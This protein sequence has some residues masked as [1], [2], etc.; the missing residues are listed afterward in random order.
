LNACSPSPCAQSVSFSFDWGYTET[1]GFFLGNVIPGSATG[2]TTGSLGTFGLTSPGFA[3]GF[4]GFF[5]SNPSLGTSFDTFVGNG[6]LESAP[7]SPTFFGAQMFGC[8]TPTCETDFSGLKFPTTG[9]VDIGILNYSV[10]EIPVPEPST[11]ALV[12]CGLL[13][14]V[15]L[16]RFRTKLRLT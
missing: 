9:T 4:L 7:I 15:V 12:A 6:L 11:L 2:V 5:S 8:L 14:T 13:A 1:S 3:S 16:I 10:K